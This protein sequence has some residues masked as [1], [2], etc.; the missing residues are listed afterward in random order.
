MS[1]VKVRE[2]VDV[3]DL[4]ELAPAICDP[5]HSQEPQYEVIEVKIPDLGKKVKKRRELR[6]TAM[7]I[8]AY[9]KKRFLD[10][11]ID[12]AAVFKAVLSQDDIKTIMN[13]GL[14][15]AALA[16]SPSDKL[17]LTWGKIK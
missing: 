13:S 10:G 17:S 5:Y 7:R 8:Q 1:V 2:P 3:L 12:D 16:L 6:K 15:V 4:S 14:Q 11:R 9:V